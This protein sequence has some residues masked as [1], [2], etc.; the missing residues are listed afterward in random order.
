MY[1]TFELKQTE[2]G[3]IQGYSWHVDDP[4]KVVCIV[5]GIGEYGGRYDRVA[6]KFAEAGIATL[7]MDLRGHGD[8][9]NPKGHCAPRK[10]VLA[11]ISDLILYAQ[12]KYPGKDIIL[13]GH[14]MGGNLTF[15]YRSRGDFNNVP[16][17]YLISAPWVRLVNPVKGATYALAKAMSKIAPSMGTSSTVDEATLGHPDSVKPYKA[18]PM[19]HDRISFLCAVEGIDIGKALE[20]GVHESNG[21]SADIPTMIMHGTA[22]KICDIEGTRKVFQNLKEKGEKVEFIEWP[23][24]FHEIHN[25]NAENRGDEVIDRIIEFILE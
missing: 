11:D 15:D 22:D 8:S 5:H 12:K 23:G 2:K 18:N 24:Y 7:S 4:K 3:K 9:I 20:D 10:N 1:E 14:S 25:G 19:V 16:S 6:M 21:R 13:Y 17:K